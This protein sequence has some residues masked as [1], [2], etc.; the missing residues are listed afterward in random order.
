M[1]LSITPVVIAA[2]LAIPGIAGAQSMP[3]P[4]DVSVGPLGT[5]PSGTTDTVNP[6]QSKAG[7]IR[8]GKMAR[9]RKILG[10]TVYNDQNEAIGSVNQLLIS[11]NNDIEGIVLSIG[12]ATGTSGRL[13][14][15]P[16]IDIRVLPDRVLMSNASKDQLKQL[17]DFRPKPAGSS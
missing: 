2:M 14:K 6:A 11:Q 9:A 10:A 5:R 4:G 16:A 1:R 13:V 3:P 7:Y 8:S 17:P 12:G 15:V